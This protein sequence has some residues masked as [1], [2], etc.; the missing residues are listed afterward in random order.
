MG[1]LRGRRGGKYGRQSYPEM[2]NYE[3]VL[4]SRGTVP[5]YVNFWKRSLTT[6]ILRP[7]HPPPPLHTAG[8]V[9]WIPDRPGGSGKENNS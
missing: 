4:E 9:W 3:G 5:V 1:L 7:I 2:R 6:L 8:K